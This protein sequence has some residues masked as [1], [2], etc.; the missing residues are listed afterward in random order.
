[1][2][3]LTIWCQQNGLD[4]CKRRCQA[5]SLHID[6]V[7]SPGYWGREAG[8]STL[9]ACD[10]LRLHGAG[11]PITRR[12]NSWN[13]EME[14]AWNS[15][16]IKN[17]TAGRCGTERSCHAESSYSPLTS[18]VSFIP[19]AVLHCPS[20]SA[21]LLGGHNSCRLLSQRTPPVLRSTPCYPPQ[22]WLSLCYGDMDRDR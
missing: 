20:L 13:L 22:H 6:R 14:G 11:K 21:L 16:R 12:K 5:V 15:F 18:Y 2:R 17:N 3:G 4:G 10:L 9:K 8:Q 1:M 19:A 7:T